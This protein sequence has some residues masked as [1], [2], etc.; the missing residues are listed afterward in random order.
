MT[1]IK[2]NNW[3][4]DWLISQVDAWNNGWRIG[5]FDVEYKVS[6]TTHTHTYTH[7]VV[8]LNGQ[9]SRLPL[10]VCC[11][12]G[13]VSHPCQTRKEELH[14]VLTASLHF[15]CRWLLKVWSSRCCNELKC[16]PSL[17][18]IYAIVTNVSWDSSRQ[19][20]ISLNNL[21]VCVWLQGILGVGV[22]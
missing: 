6:H 4:T 19:F 8:I 2:T 11:S 17:Q 22:N 5:L 1:F 20:T 21:C 14:L 7:T 10:Q 15:Q 13:K 16:L 18:C 12:C 9:C 3:I